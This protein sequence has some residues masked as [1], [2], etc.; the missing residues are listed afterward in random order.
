[1]TVPTVPANAVRTESLAL[2][3]FQREAVID[4][5][6]LKEETR[7]FEVVWSAG[8]EVRRFDWMTGQR[9]VEV[10]EVSD[11]AVRLER[12]QSGAAPVLDSHGRWSL[13]DV[14]GVVEKGS[15]RIEGGKAYA[16]VRMSGREE[17]AGIVGDIKDGIIRNMS[18]GYVVHAFRE[19]KRGET[20]YRIVT[21]W[22][23]SELSF[24][25][26][27]ADADAGLRSA[28]G[29]AAPDPKLPTYPCLATRAAADPA[30][31]PCGAALARM[32]MRQRAAGI[33]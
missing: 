16:Q 19:E 10:L 22:E 15:V 18:C 7:A 9:Y 2:P 31:V 33:V 20:L 32:R 14:I 13:Q 1:M 23:P 8:A 28:D 12:L 21:D 25:P 4:P 24:V 11:K 26:I 3:A 5:K 17:V 27:G 29:K 6:S 30:P